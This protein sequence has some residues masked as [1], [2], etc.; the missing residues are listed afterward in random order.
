MPPEIA[1]KARKHVLRR[2][3]AQIAHSQTSEQSIPK[4]I[5]QS[6]VIAKK[7]GKL[8]LVLRRVV[9]DWVASGGFKAEDNSEDW[10][11]ITDRTFFS[12]WRPLHFLFARFE[13]FEFEMVCISVV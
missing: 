7:V 6:D 1:A 13:C 3:Q 2:T 10:I 11:C 5:K 8:D 12:T 4:K 9:R